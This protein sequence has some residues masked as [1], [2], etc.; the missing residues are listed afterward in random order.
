MRY[1]IATGIL[2]A[3]LGAGVGY[4]LGVRGGETPDPALSA[5]SE[6]VEGRDPAA[7]APPASQRL[8]SPR[9]VSATGANPKPPNLFDIAAMVS[10]FDQTA[11]LYQLLAPLKADE[12]DRLIDEAAQAFSGSDYRAATAIMIARLAE[13][14]PELAVLRLASADGRVERQWTHAIYHSW[15]RQDL[16]AAL[17]SADTLKPGDRRMAG[18]A[19][20]EAREDLLL[21]QRRDIAE[22]TGTQ[23]LIADRG[24]FAEAWNDALDES[25]MQQRF[26]KLAVV[27]AQWG[28]ADPLA[29]MAALESLPPEAMERSVSSQII[30]GWARQD[31]QGALDWVLENGDSPQASVMLSAVLQLLSQDD[32][33]AALDVARSLPVE[34]RQNAMHSLLGTWVSADPQAATQWVLNESADGERESYLGTMAALLAHQDQEAMSEWLDELPPEDA[35]KLLPYSIN[36]LARTDPLEAVAQIERIDDPTARVGAVESLTRVWARQDPQAAREWLDTQPRATREAAADD[37]INGWA[38]RDAEGALAYTL[39]QP[40]GDSRDQMLVGLIGRLSAEQAET[41]VDAIDN[42]QMRQSAQ[43]LRQRLRGLN[44]SSSLSIQSYP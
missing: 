3:L 36:A 10:D 32:L 25:N 38:R 5:T 34:Q 19:I 29:A 43:G 13:I 2:S 21:A 1:L 27:A 14:D 44:R 37:L 33:N 35:T 42:A 20:L 4:V 30:H 17:A 16:D 11:G 9:N 12:I 31:P 28:M 18:R 26:Q 40:G 7:A 6:R 24:N 15:A 8:D 39:A 41:A 22:R 23:L